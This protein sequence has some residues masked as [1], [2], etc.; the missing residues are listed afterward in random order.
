MK[1]E[2][3]YY[4]CYATANDDKFYFVDLKNLLNLKVTCSGLVSLNLYIVISKVRGINYYDK[5]F[6]WLVR[7]CFKNHPVINLKSVVFKTN[8]GRDFSSYNSM[9]NNL[10]DEN[11]NDYLFFQN[12]SGIGPLKENWYLDFIN[13]FERFENTA[14]VG[15]TVSFLDFPKRSNRA[16]LPHVQTYAFMTNLYMLN[17]LEDGFPARLKKNRKDIICEGEIGLSQFYLKKGYGISCI[18]WPD[19]LIKLNTKAVFFKD[20]RGLVS[21]NHQ[22]KHKVCFTQETG[23]AKRKKYIQLLVSFCKKNF[24]QNSI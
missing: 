7:N 4:H 2:T 24:H 10:K 21:A 15:S 14:L 18:E 11:S 20:P 13:Q 8:I 5:F 12:R 9:L 1:K 17:Q 6:V 19:K 23:W 16:D 22:F 3:K